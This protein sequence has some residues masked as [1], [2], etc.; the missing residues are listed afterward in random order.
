MAERTREMRGVRPLVLDIEGMSCTSC[1][2]RV[3]KALSSREGVREAE[4]DFPSH[5]AKVVVEGAVAMEELLK[6]VE[7]AG[8]RARLAEVGEVAVKTYRV[9]GMSCTSCAQRVKRALEK[10]EGVQEAEVSFASGEARVVLQEEVPDEVLAHAVED[11]GYRLLWEEEED[12][13]ERYLRQER[14]RLIAAWVLTGPAAVLMVMRMFFGISLVP[15]AIVPWLDLA[16][17]GIV[18]LALGWPV[19]KSTWYAFRHLSFTMDSLIGIGALASLSTGVLRQVGV[20]I[21]DFSLVG[22]MILSIHLIGNYL[23]LVATGRASQAIR[24]LLELGAKVAHRIR[25]D[26]QIEDVPVQALRKGDLVLVRPGEKIPSDGVIVEG[27]T[28]VDESIATGESV[29]ADRGPGDQ[30]IGATV[31]QQGAITVR[32]EKV[33]KETFLAQVARMVQEAQA[34]KVPIQEFADRVTAVFVPV[35]LSISAAT[36]VVW[37]LLPEALGEVMRWAAGFLPWVDPSRGVVSMALFAAIATLV[38]ACPCALGLATPTALMVGM[39]LGAEHGILIRSGKAIQIAQSVQDV[40]FDKTGTLTEGK[41]R[42]V[43][44]WAPGGEEEL[45]RLLWAVESASEHPLARAVCAWAEERGAGGAQ[46]Q[47]V[48]AVPGKGVRGVVGGSVVLAGRQEWLEEEGVATEGFAG[49]A[50]AAYGRGETVVWVAQ[51]GRLVG[52]VSLADTLKPSSKEAVEALKELGIRCIMLTG[53]NERA[54]RAIASQVGIDEVRA[55]LLPQDKIGVIRELQAQGR[56]VAM[57][58]DGINDA[59]ALTQADVGIAIGTGTDIA[60]ESADITLVSEN[61]LGVPRAIGLSRATFRKIRQ[62]LFWAF[63]YNVIAIPIAVLGLLHPVVAEI[64][65]AASSVNVVTN[66]LRLRRARL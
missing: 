15:V 58:G 7:E 5:R 64:A 41:P 55:R 2:Q 62:N 9:E 40:V 24:R 57:V 19:V 49:E 22:A 17:A 30:V 47:G 18:V 28:A 37:L 23:K 14:R 45:A 21:E 34:S 8:Y 33:G 31:N 48:E 3:K 50:E 4:V 27:H 26:G 16:I 6:A 32:I 61:M 65:M 13:E 25:E 51:D 46:A 59:P 39:G 1:A 35:V 53:D 52:L 63:F 54:A 12:A 38:I 29:P 36:F 44:V 60:I 56:V 43:G 11:A 42:V 10:V 20:D 66:S